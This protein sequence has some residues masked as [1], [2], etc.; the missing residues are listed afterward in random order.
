VE[1]RIILH[2]EAKK[3]GLWR[4]EGGVCCFSRKEGS[5]E[6]FSFEIEKKIGVRSSVQGVRQNFYQ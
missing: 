2:I 6:Y 5:R 3:L 1:V 4:G